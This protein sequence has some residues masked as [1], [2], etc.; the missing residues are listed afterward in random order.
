MRKHMVVGKSVARVDALDKVTGKAKYAADFR[1][2]GMLFAKVARSPYAHARILGIDSSESEKLRGVRAVV[3]PEDAPPGRMGQLSTCDRQLLPRD[4]IVRFVGEPVAIV[5]ADTLDIAEE[6]VELIKIEYEELAA[7]F[8]PEVAMQKDC[9]A[10]IHPD[11]N[12]YAASSTKGACQP[13]PDIP[14]IATTFKLRKGDIEQG[15]REAALIVENRF[16]F[17]SESQGRIERYITDAWID[18]DGTYVVRKTNKGLWR[19]KDWLCSLFNMPP[20]RIRVIQSY[21]G[22]DFGGRGTALLEGLALLGAIKTGRKVRLEYSREEE[23]I[24]TCN[25]PRVLIDVKDGVRRDGTILARETRIV[26]D[27]GAYV[28]AGTGLSPLAIHSGIIACYD[29]PNWN[30]DAVTV[31]T[32]N[33]P[34]GT[35]R[36]I[37][38]PRGNWAIESQMDIIAHELGMD[39]V[40][41][42]RKNVVSEGDNNAYGQAL[43]HISPRE[44]LE[45]ATELLEWGKKTELKDNWQTGKGVALGNYKTKGFWPSSVVVKLLRDGTVEVRHGTDEVGQGINTVLAQLA[46]EEFKISVDEVRVVYGDTMYVPWDWGSSASRCTW[47]TGSAAVLACRDAKRQLFELAAK[48]IEE[49]PKNLDTLGGRVFSK[50]MPEKSIPISSL[51]V[52]DYAIG[53]GEILG[54]G[55]FQG[56]EAPQDPVTGQCANLSPCWPYLAYGVEVAVNKLTGEV[57]VLGLTAAIDI[58]QPINWKMCEGQIE[59]GMGMGVGQGIYEQIVLRDGVTLNPNFVTYRIPTTMEMPSTKNVQIVSVGKPHPEGPYG[60]KSLGEMTLI[61]FFAALGNAVYD[62]VGVRIK[63][64]PITRERILKALKETGK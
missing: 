2:P 62:A 3:R 61:P 17:A 10:V 21:I 4:M 57:K 56:Y 45:K 53:S 41:I 22:G 33:P 64:A 51:F 52:W 23:F 42:R 43:Y 37:D 25:G 36:G 5:V 32:N 49:S 26:I 19:C 11:K 9:P 27:G 28:G 8:D 44:C 46:A 29:I 7:L 1:E 14:N 16:T 24:D 20:S 54:K 31:Y 39:P 60:A 55:N 59:G 50:T 47:H 58:G 40:E 18:G 35:L 13:C 38:S 30:S 63:D 6:G 12:N 15:F 48:K 34:T